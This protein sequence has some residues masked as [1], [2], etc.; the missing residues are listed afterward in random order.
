MR[1]RPGTARKGL[2]NEARN[3]RDFKQS[4][5]LIRFTFRKFYSGCSVENKLEEGKLTSKKA[6]AESQVR[7]DS[8]LYLGSENLDRDEAKK[9]KVM[10]FLTGKPKTGVTE[11]LLQ[12]TAGISL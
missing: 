7:E 11:Q 5:V 12:L 6:V 1:R 9:K 2:V 10:K 8:S 3:L 4:N